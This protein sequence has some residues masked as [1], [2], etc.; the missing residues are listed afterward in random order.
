MR[1][2]A[3]AEIATYNLCIPARVSG[4]ETAL[5]VKGNLFA[6][7]YY[8]DFFKCTLAFLVGPVLCLFCPHT[9]KSKC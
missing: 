5:P 4:G 9:F 1:F 8:C 7:Y 2:Y 3:L 6:T